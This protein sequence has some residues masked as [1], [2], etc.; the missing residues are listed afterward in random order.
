MATTDQGPH[1]G[2]THETSAGYGIPNISPPYD[3]SDLVERLRVGVFRSRVGPD[4]RIEHGNAALVSL[5]D[6]GTLDAL[7]S[8]RVIDLWQHAEDRNRFIALLAAQGRIVNE[9]F[10]FVTL[11]G[12]RFFGAV[13]A[14]LR[15]GAGGPC[16]EGLIEDITERC[17]AREA[18]KALSATKLQ[19][20][21]AREIQ[22]RLLPPGPPLFPGFD[23]AGA[24]FPAD[25]VGGDYFDFI[26][27]PSD[28]LTIAIG[29]ASGHG[30]GPALIMAET[31]ACLWA[32]APL[33]A[34]LRETL[35]RTNEVI[36]NSTPESFFITLALAFLDPVTRQLTYASCGHPTGYVL[37]RRG[38]VRHALTSTGLPLGCVADCNPTLAEPVQ[39]QAGDTVLLI[40]D[41]IIEARST[42]TQA[43]YAEEG[44]L[45]AAARHIH[46]PA[47]GMIEAVYNDVREF[48]DGEPTADDATVVVAKVR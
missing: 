28:Y 15:S 29:D 39:L 46:L 5:F 16:I 14:S 26:P 43:F 25:A 32:L 27:G 17:R 12:R 11:T 6:A 38:E 36:Y 7:R 34:S 24:A 22:Y 48:C 45:R 21:I 13:T 8:R 42:R 37:D 2:A 20:R 23:L 44:L 19:L 1:R 35:Q 33:S 41:G 31:R 4:A 30:L 40:T 9:E 3:Y 47:V 18:D 10:E